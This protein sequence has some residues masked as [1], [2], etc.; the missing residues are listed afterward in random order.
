MRTRR[1]LA[2]CA[3]GAVIVAMASPAVGQALQGNPTVVAGSA[4]IS[5][6]A[7]TT[8]IVIRA[9]DLLEVAGMDA[10]EIGARAWAA[11]LRLQE[12]TPMRASLEDIFMDLTKDAVEYHGYTGNDSN[13]S[14]SE[15]VA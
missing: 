14:E 1:L 9:P 4:A 7:G 11:N 6:G 5:T 15:M 12:L 10:D 13:H 3:T 8:D 2:G